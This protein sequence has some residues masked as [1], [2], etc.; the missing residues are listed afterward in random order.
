M[1]PFWNLLKLL[2]PLILLSACDIGED[3]V[4]Y[5]FVSLTTV[6]VDMPEEFRLNET[7]EI[8]VTVLEPNGCTEFAGFDIL[9]ENTTIR[10]VVAIGTE[11]DDVPCTE[12]LSE[13]ATSFDFICLYSGTYTFRF[14]TGKN[15]DGVDQFMEFEVPV[16]P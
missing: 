16:V 3:E 9:P 10:R 6:S 13:V 2:L 7:Y 15:E 1:K 8:G 5:H 14:W 4:S 11:Q 12:V